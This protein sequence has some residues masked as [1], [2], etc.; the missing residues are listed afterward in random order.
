MRKREKERYRGYEWPRPALQPLEV[1]VFHSTERPNASAVFGATL[2]PRGLSGLI[3]RL[4]FRKSENAYAHWLPLLLADRVDMLEGLLSDL[5]HGRPPN[6][7]A[8]KGLR[9]DWKH[10]RA[11]L[12]AKAAVGT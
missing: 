4:A 3:R 1:E 8:E 7:I 11:R 5:L 2:P 6:L 10:D 12:V 9:A